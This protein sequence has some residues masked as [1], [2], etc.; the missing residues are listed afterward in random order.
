MKTARNLFF[1]AVVLF[2]TSCVSTAKFPVSSV[3]PA[4]EIIAKM[5]QDKNKNN[6]IEVTA[7][8]MASADRLTPPK[9]NYVV[10]IETENNGIKNIGRLTNKNAKKAS[11][12]TSTPFT[13]KE[14]FITA[15][16]QDDISYPSGTEI[17]RTRFTSK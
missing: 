10:W 4:A 12:K 8:N 16:E 3:T 7:L 14:I 5:K 11:L 17:S 2:L 1:G 15:E 6:V 13:V 9:S